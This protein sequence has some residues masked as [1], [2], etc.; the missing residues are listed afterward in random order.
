MTPHSRLVLQRDNPHRAIAIAAADEAPSRFEIS[1]E[2]FDIRLDDL[3]GMEDIAVRLI[4]EIQL[5][6]RRPDI[7]DQFGLKPLRGVLLYSYKPGMGK[8]KFVSA[9]ARWFYDHSD[10]IGYEVVL[11]EVKPNETKIVWH[12][13]DAKI[14]RE[15]WDKIRARQARSRTRPLIQIVVFDEVDSLGRRGAA[16]DIVTSSAQNDALQALLVEMDGLARGE[17]QDGPP[18]HVI[19][20]GMTNRP[21]MVDSAATRPGRFGDLILSM[22]PV[23]LV[24]AEDV[25]AIY[26]RGSELPWYLGGEVCTGVDLEQ[27]RAHMLRPALA[28]VFDAVVVRYKTDTQRSIDATA[29]EIMANVHFMD[30]MNSAK[31]RAAVRCWHNSGVPAVSYDDVVDCLLDSA[32]SVAQQ[33]EA[34]PQMLIR[35]LQVK[36]PVTRVDAVDK[37]ELAD[38]RY[39]R[40]HSA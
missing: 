9:I 7:R 30:A 20:F 6:I 3:A 11:Y 40:V 33:M 18:S 28:S 22:P 27:I 31:K 14:I 13:G 19:C 8:S 32:L 4:E 21:D 29:G 37:R 16:N 39:L 23:T 25:M 38:H 12:G 10:S 24:S 35:H 34:D 1:I 26:A 36:V 5:R 2:N 15:L 17:S